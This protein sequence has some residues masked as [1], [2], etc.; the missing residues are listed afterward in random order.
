M[1]G[2][3]VLGDGWETTDEGLHLHD[4]LAK[5]KRTTVA[6]VTGTLIY[7]VQTIKVNA[8][9]TRILL[10]MPALAGDTV[11]ADLKI[12]NS[13]GV[14]VYETSSAVGENDT[15]I[16]P[17]DPVV[18]LVGTNTVVLTLTKDSGGSGEAAVTIYV[19]G[20]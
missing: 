7:T 15:H 4:K 9:A 17:L 8:N 5:T 2:T 20:K 10:E 13:D 16:L 3:R 18:P 19:E 12:T 14:P 6:I 11:T 1:A